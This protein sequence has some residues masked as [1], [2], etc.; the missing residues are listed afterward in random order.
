MR[1]YNVAL[2]E[3]AVVAATRGM[4]GAGAGLLLANYLRPETRRTVGWT[5]FAIGA[6]ST[7]PI[8]MALFGRRQAVQPRDYYDEQ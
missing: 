6:L 4:A 1:T 3:M 5:L 2:P 8:A 7:I